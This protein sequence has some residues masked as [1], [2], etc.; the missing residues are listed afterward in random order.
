M[1]LRILVLASLWAMAFMIWLLWKWPPPND[2][3]HRPPR[4]YT[5]KP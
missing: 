1:S 5:G 2:K 3:V 4:V